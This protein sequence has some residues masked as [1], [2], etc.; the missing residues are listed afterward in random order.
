MKRPD[1]VWFG[2]RPR[3]LDEV[4]AASDIA[5]H[6]LIVGTSLSVSPANKLPGMVLRNNLRDDRAGAPQARL[7]EINPE[8]HCKLAECRHLSGNAEDILPAFVDSFLEENGA[9]RP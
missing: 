1:V 9:F 2:E 4:L 8:R 6:M 3:Y 5:T 7:Y